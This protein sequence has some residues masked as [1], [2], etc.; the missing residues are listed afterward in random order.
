MRSLGENHPRASATNNAG[1]EPKILV[2]DAT[3]YHVSGAT[4]GEFS[5]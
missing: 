2:S 3:S 4:D 5:A 1:T